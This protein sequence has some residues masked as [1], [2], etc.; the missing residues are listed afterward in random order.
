MVDEEVVGVPQLLILQTINIDC[1]IILL[2]EKI[3]IWPM[4][5]VEPL[6]QI[7]NVNELHLFC[8]PNCGIEN[9]FVSIS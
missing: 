7:M 9:H 3:L 5:Q 1:V 4:P 6:M 2:P 8:L